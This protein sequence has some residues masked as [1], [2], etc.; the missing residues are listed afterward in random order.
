[1]RGDVV[2]PRASL[3]SLSLQVFP[4]RIENAE[5]TRGHEE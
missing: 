1:V 3:V 5:N 2:H 4:R